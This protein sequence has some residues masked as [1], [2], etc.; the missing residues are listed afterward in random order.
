MTNQFFT[1]S[2]LNHL[3]IKKMAKQKGIIKLEGTIGDITFHKS[4]DGY[5]AKE[6]SS[7]SAERIANDPAFQRTRENGAEFGRAGKAGKVLRNALR[8]LL[9]NASD[10]RVV[11]RLTREMMR[12][13]QTD[14]INARG[15]RTV[16]EGELGFLEGFDFNIDGKLSTTLYAPYTTTINRVAGTVEI[17][18]AAFIP[19]VMVSA[20][21]GTTHFRIFAAGAEVDFSTN[22][23][24]SQVSDSGIMPWDNVPTAAVTLSHSLTANSTK[25]LFAVLGIEFLQEV[26]GVQYPL[27]NGAFNAMAIVKVSAV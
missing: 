8:Q 12:V 24:V 5:I 10:S 16:T 9:Q 15:E 7:V 17:A 23:T 6:K 13:I 11:S 14:P 22:S 19:A 3:K 20:P 4:R 26:N 18:L 27:K 21:S 1:A 25:P 2:F